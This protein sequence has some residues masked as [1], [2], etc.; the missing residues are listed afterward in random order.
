MTNIFYNNVN[1]FSGISPTPLVSQKNIFIKYG[2]QWGE[3][4]KVTLYG[5]IYSKCVSGNFSLVT[6]T[7]NQTFQTS[8]GA[9]GIL[10]SGQQS[11]IKSFSQDFQSL[12][13]VQDGQV[14]VDK[15]LAIIRNIV[16]PDSPYSYYVPFQIELDCYESGF[17]SGLFGVLEPKNEFSF[18]QNKDQS[19]TIEHS[20]SCRGFN[21]DSNNSNALQNAVQYIQSIS[22]FRNQ[23]LPYFINFG[24]G[25]YGTGIAPSLIAQKENINRV[26]GSYSLEE[27]YIVDPFFS[28]GVLRYATTYDSGISDGI[29]TV[30]VNGS[31][32]TSRNYPIDFIRSRYSAF[33]SFSAAVDAYSGAT[34][35]LLDLNPFY[36]SSGISEDSFGGVINFNLSFNNDQTPNPFLDYTVTF[37]RDNITDVTS[38]AFQGTI[39]GRGDLKSRYDKVLAFSS[40]VNVFNL[41]LG[42]YY[43]N[44]YQYIL[45]PLYLSYSNTRNPYAG[46]IT[47][48]ATYDDK[49]LPVSG[50]ANLQYSYNFTPS[51]EQFS[52]IPILDGLGRYVVTDLGFTNRATF[53]MEGKAV[54]APNL[55]QSTGILLLTN[56][57]NGQISTL[58]SG[59]SRIALE[60]QNIS[61][62]NQGIGKD[63]TF[64]VSYSYEDFV[65]DI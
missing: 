13:I 8:D 35:G 26:Q 43:N 27:T 31:L 47:L 18:T 19:I 65:L 2:E 46:E 59:K 39:K 63:L 3:V 52:A 4:T 38:A 54:I 55:S 24:S 34:N 28:S 12:Q 36:L 64:S 37:N 14:I 21:T 61:F 57:V 11:L 30:K 33:D 23:I 40:G 51:I 9:F 44:G 1:P 41:T 50:F 53:I 25:D 5:N 17:F 42:E 20:M 58:I 45:N 6:D 29:S 48:A 62:G 10:L 22:G 15:P 16:F 7:S 32:K 49:T 56:F 60:S